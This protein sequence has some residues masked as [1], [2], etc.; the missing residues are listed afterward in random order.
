MKKLSEV[1]FE[2]VQIRNPTLEE[3]FMEFYQEDT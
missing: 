1:D 3:S 2:D